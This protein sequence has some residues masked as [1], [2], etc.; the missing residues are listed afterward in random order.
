MTIIAFA[1]FP[2]EKL[3]LLAILAL[4]CNAHAQLNDVVGGETRLGIDDIKLNLAFERTYSGIYTVPQTIVLKL[5]KD[6]NGQQI[7]D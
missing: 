5:K 4:G 6:Q 2:N 3:T 1:N 7:W